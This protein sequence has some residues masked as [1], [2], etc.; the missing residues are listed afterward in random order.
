MI[1]PA[2]VVSTLEADTSVE[3]MSPYFLSLI[4]NNLV[5]RPTNIAHR[6]VNRA[7]KKG[8]GARRRLTGESGPK[9]RNVLQPVGHASNEDRPSVLGTELSSVPACATGAANV[10]TNSAIT[11]RAPV[12]MTRLGALD[13]N[14]LLRN[15]NDI[16]PLSPG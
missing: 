5:S 10:M 1:V 16:I 12:R 2:R 13:E 11:I 4:A 6:L 15:M 7:E 8:D 3:R 9:R 14:F